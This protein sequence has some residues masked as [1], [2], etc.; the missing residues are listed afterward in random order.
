[1]ET[2][3]PSISRSCFPVFSHSTYYNLKMRYFSYQALGIFAL[4]LSTVIAAGRPYYGASKQESKHEPENLEVEVAF[5][6][7]RDAET[8]ILKEE[9]EEVLSHLI[10]VALAAAVKRDDPE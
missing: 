1:M 3:P 4:Q 9:M 5:E 2:F 10:P 6:N 8:T 7:F